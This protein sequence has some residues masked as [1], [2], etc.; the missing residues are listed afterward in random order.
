M[1]AFVTFGVVL[2]LGVAWLNAR[3]ARRLQKE[4]ETLE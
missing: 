4:I 2:F 1:V 3:T